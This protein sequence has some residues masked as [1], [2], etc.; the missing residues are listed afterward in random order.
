MQQRTWIKL[1]KGK[2]TKTQ[3]EQRKKKAHKQL[4]LENHCTNS[5]FYLSLGNK[6][7]Y[8]H[9]NNARLANNQTLFESTK[10]MRAK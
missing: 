10:L 1:C 7:A 8:N 6:T 3:M 4:T 9:T 2:P 5:I